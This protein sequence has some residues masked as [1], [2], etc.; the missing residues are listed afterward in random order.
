M[1]ACTIY[2]NLERDFEIGSLRCVYTIL[3]SGQRT[4]SSE[5]NLPT[6]FVGFVL[7]ARDESIASGKRVYDPRASER[8]D[9]HEVGDK[10]ITHA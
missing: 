5:S 9:K 8:Q 2:K 7:G 10:L 6:I 1:Y 4:S 3:N